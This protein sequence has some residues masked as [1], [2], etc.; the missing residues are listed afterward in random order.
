MMKAFSAWEMGPDVEI[1]IE[2][3][4]VI[5][6]DTPKP[7]TGP[8]KVRYTGISQKATIYCSIEEAEALAQQ[9]LDSAQEARRQ[10]KEYEQYILDPCDTCTE[11]GIDCD[12][13]KGL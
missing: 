13:C 6:L 1:N 11:E 3:K 5:L 2:G 10:Q 8:G 9:L 7:H 12:K 4:D